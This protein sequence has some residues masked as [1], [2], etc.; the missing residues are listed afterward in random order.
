VARLEMFMDVTIHSNPIIAVKKA[1][2]GLQ[3]SIMSGEKM[4]V[5][6]L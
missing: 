2:F 3:N 1:L 5:C 4:S 6:F